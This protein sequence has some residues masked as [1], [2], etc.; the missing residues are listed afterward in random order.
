LIPLK[1]GAGNAA[2][3]H[4]AYQHALQAAG[5]PRRQHAFPHPFN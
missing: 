1:F 2:E 3:G 4:P 5:R